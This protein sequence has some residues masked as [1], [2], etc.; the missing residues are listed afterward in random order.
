MNTP[1]V[2]VTLLES[3]ADMTFPMTIAVEHG[4]FFFLPWHNG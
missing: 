4:S 3:A 1:D 2:F